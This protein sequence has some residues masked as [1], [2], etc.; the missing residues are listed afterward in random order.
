MPI[1]KATA[2]SV[3][4]AAKGD[5]VVGSATNDAAV[6]GVGSNDQVL[7]ADSSTATGLK[8]AT[9][10]SGGVTLI[11]ETTAS[12]ISSLTLGS[13]PGTY[14]HIM[15]TWHGIYVSASGQT[16]GLRFNNDSTASQYSFTGV[17]A[18]PTTSSFGGNNDNANDCANGTFFPYDSTS[19]SDYAQAAKGFC[20]IYDYAST[21]KYKFYSLRDSR[22]Y[23]G[24]AK[25]QMNQ[26]DGT[27]KSTSAIT[28]LDI[29][30]ASGSGTFSNQ[31]N[32]SIRLY[33]I[34]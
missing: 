12:A 9:A 1:T 31:S 21:S 6:L 16:F 34:S 23:V 3:A 22:R 11:S 32:T 13:I 14:K 7:T 29:Y 24:A 27:Y 2:S 26:V 8:W 5:L 10:S 33:G 20:I 15:L 19:S 28:S 25:W 30:R 18:D 4:P 17:N